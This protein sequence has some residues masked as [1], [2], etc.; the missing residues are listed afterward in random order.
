MADLIDRQGWIPCAKQNPDYYVDVLITTTVTVVVAWRDENGDYCSD[1][2]YYGKENV[3][4]WMPLP[5][6]YEEE[7]K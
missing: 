5:K 1:G 2:V 3:L 7:Q 4:A 6:P